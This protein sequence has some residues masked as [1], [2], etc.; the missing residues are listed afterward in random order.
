VIS[1]LALFI[2]L[3]G[4]ATALRGKN[5]VRSD[6]IAKGQVKSPDIRGDAVL[7]R[8]IRSG[9]VSGA[10]VQNGTL[11][12]ADVGAD[13]LTGNEIQESSLGG[14]RRFGDQI[15]SGTTVIGVWGAGLAVGSASVLDVVVELP[16]PAPAPLTETT[17]NFADN[18]NATVGDADAACTG[19]LDAPTAPAG[20]VC[21]YAG[22]NVGGDPTLSGSNIDDGLQ[23]RL[24]FIVFLDPPP[25]TT[26]MVEAHGTWAYTA[27]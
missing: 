5:S 27:P 19:S 7:G 9:E 20:K 16:A 14:L 23:D 26:T 18:G 12:A 10:D 6:D 21:L 15:P 4:T 11:G 24:G 3:G 17:V 22:T 25:A 8:H 2:A 13:S 1:I